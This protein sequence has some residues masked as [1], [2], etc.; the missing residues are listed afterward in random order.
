MLVVI[1]VPGWSAPHVPFL[2]PVAAV[3][4]DRV[5]RADHRLLIA[6]ADY[7]PV[8]DAWKGDRLPSSVDEGRCAVVPPGHVFLASPAPQSLDSRYFGPVAVDAI[9]A[10][11]TPLLVWR[12]ADA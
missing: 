4:G 6:G 11:A 12:P 7:G 9:T 2:K 3:A 5:C 1:Q 10:T 8:Y